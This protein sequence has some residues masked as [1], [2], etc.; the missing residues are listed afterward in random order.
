MSATSTD[1]TK[2]TLAVIAGGRGT[3]MG[4]PKVAM[5][6]DGRPILA[7][8][9]DRLRWPGPT[10]LV[11]APSVPAVEEAALFDRHV[12]DPV[13]D[14]GPLRGVLTALEHAS[15]ETIVA[16]PVDMPGVDRA[17]LA[18]LVG[19]LSSQPDVLGVMTQAVEIEPFPSAYRTTARKPIADRLNA[20]RRSLHGLCDDARFVA[21]A[22]PADWSADTWTNLNAPS[23]LAA[24]ETQLRKQ[25]S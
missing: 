24:F 7:W 6:I 14:L 9:I 16:I 5:R 17:K 22:A 21:V 25:T 23:E 13:D 8:L 15:T 12:V 10:M 4:G 1:L 18:W 11:T 3:R 19:K 20:G 2:V